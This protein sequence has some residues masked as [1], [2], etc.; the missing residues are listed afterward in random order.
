MYIL[1]ICIIYVILAYHDISDLEFYLVAFALLINLYL[2]MHKHEYFVVQQE[3]VQEEGPA[4][5]DKMVTYTTLFNLPNEMGNVLLPKFDYVISGLKG[6]SGSNADATHYVDASDFYGKKDPDVMKDDL[7]TVDEEKI[8]VLKTNY[9][10]LN[11]MF[12]NLS[13]ISPT[14][15]NQIFQ[16]NKSN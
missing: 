6:N 12:L 10:D 5:D 8:N 4:I 1:V 16:T 9:R 7:K 11:T 3:T 2:I 13:N 15:Y 14:L